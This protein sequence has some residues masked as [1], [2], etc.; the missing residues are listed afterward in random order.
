MNPSNFE[1]QKTLNMK[2][3]LL[4]TSFFLLLTVLGLACRK[5]VMN[6]EQQYVKKVLSE[7]SPDLAKRLEQL[8]KVFYQEGLDKKLI[9]NIDQKLVW[10]PDWKHPKVQTVNDSTSYV[11]FKLLAYVKQGSKL[12]EAKEVDAASYLMIKNEQDFYKALYRVKNGPGE[13]EVDLTHFSGR[14]LLNS[15]K[16]NQSFLLNYLNGKIVNDAKI[17]LDKLGSSGGA[18]KIPTTAYWESYCRTEIKECTYVSNELINCM[19]AIYFGVVYSY[20]CRWP[21]AV[22]DVPFYLS[23]FAYREVCQNIWFP[24]PPSPGGGGGG[25]GVGGTDT[26]SEENDPDLK[27]DCGSWKYTPVGPNGNYQACGVSKIDLD[28]IT[29]YTDTNGK[30]R[31]DYIY[32][33]FNVPIFFEFPRIRSNGFVV[34]STEA[35][36][37]SANLRDRAEKALEE[38]LGYMANP[39]GTVIENAYLEILGGLLAPFGGRVSRNSNYGT[40]PISPLKKG[41]FGGGC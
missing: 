13:I 30:L 16:N 14:L 15:L 22:C 40:V 17:S 34:S 10:E 4:K 7:K 11:F 12:M 36:T 37:I 33:K 25:G 1:I 38:R 27:S 35:A 8:K 32:Y 26:S 2:K 5:D 28:Y 39:G 20:D 21:S 3:H 19:G 18:G 9:P 23:N 24:D 6:T 31:V 29:T 41:L